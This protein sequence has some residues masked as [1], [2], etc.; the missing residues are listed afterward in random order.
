[1]FINPTI[2]VNLGN[3][4]YK[5]YEKLGYSIKKKNGYNNKPVADLPQTIEIKVEDLPPYAKGKIELKCDCCGIAFQ[6][7]IEEMTN[8][9]KNSPFDYCP[10]CAIQ[11][12]INTKLQKYGSLNPNEIS[13]QNGTKSG[14][15][16][17]YSLEQLKS[18]AEDNGYF[19]RDDL[20]NVS[21][22][23]VKNRYTFECKIH[24]IIF[25][26][27]FESILNHKESC[28]VCFSES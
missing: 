17:K 14:R 26:T 22:I 11:K 21:E 8:C 10:K 9:R 27:P 13:M 25:E 15:K 7:N 12:T 28:P 19:L 4:N 5:Y 6:R 23:L 1:M 20:C 24:N 16:R 3:R 18:L 2:S